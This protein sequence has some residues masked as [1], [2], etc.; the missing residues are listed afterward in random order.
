VEQKKQ[1]SRAVGIGALKYAMIKVSPEKTYA[2]NVKDTL[3]FDGDTAPYIQYTYARA[4][5]ILSKAESKTKDFDISALRE[6]KELA[7]I[8]KL[9]EFSE[10]VSKAARDLRPH[11]IS[12]YAY[13]LATMFNEF[14]HTSP[15]I[16]ADEKTKAARLILVEAT[17]TVIKNALSLLGIDVMERM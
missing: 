15:V 17:S 4:R 8:K 7:L 1:I 14:Y 11:Y 6:Q 13:D 5:S 2:F 12:G 10:T 3:K 16:T 9:S